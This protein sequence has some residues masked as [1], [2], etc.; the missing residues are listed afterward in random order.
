M[1]RYIVT[2]FACR[3]GK[4]AAA[5]QSTTAAKHLRQ[6]DTASR[7]T[8]VQAHVFQGMEPTY[9]CMLFKTQGLILYR[10]FASLK[11]NRGQRLFHV[12]GTNPD[13]VRAMQVAPRAASLN[14]G[15]CFI[16]ILSPDKLYVSHAES[17]PWPSFGPHLASGQTPQS[18]HPAVPRVRVHP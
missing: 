13:N 8:A 10:H 7:E 9:F 4:Q 18:C 15:D 3:Y 6:L 5:A 2:L 14:S 17:L 1:T 12:Q 11:G 16:F